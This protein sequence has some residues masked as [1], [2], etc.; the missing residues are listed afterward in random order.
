M[1]NTIFPK[2]SPVKLCWIRMLYTEGQ[3]P[4]ISCNQLTGTVTSK[5]SGRFSILCKNHGQYLEEFRLPGPTLCGRDMP[6]PL[7]SICGNSWEFLL[8]HSSMTSPDPQVTLGKRWAVGLL[9]GG[10]AALPGPSIPRARSGSVEETVPTTVSTVQSST[11]GSSHPL[12]GDR[13]VH[14]RACYD[15]R[16]WRMPIS[17]KKGRSQA[18]NELGAEQRPRARC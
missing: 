9:H 14:L 7:G 12:P 6:T 17:S 8:P 3:L 5:V 18:G 10:P 1:V 13:S 15:D 4:L 11:G 16:G 2:P